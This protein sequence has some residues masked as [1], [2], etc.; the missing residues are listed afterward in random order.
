MESSIAMQDA[1]HR[2]RT[3]L[4]ARGGRRGERHREQSTGDARC[5]SHA[6]RGGR[7]GE[8]RRTQR[9]GDTHCWS[10]AV[11]DAGSDGG[12]STGDARCW[13]YFLKQIQYTSRFVRVILALGP[14]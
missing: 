13:S 14:C 2:R 4:V 12:R 9:T 5:W 7:R 8:R 3:L 10:H 6:A 11:A 1:T